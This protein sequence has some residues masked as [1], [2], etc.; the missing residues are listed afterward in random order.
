MPITA[1]APASPN[2]AARPPVTGLRFDI[3]AIA[4]ATMP[5]S[6]IATKILKEVLPQSFQKFLLSNQCRN[7]PMTIT[8]APPSISGSA[9]DRRTGI[10]APAG[11]P[12]VPAGP[13]ATP[14][15]LV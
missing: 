9:V 6:A 8:A 2:S 1:P 5:P 13:P 7:D 12:V 3:Q 14:A 11:A 4:S 15:P 10:P